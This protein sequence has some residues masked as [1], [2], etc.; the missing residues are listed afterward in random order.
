M[1]SHPHRLHVHRHVRDALRGVDEYASADPVRRLRDLLH[2][3]DGA[4][5]VGHV[6]QRH[7]PRVGRQQLVEVG[8]VERVVRADGHQ[9]QLGV[10]H[11]RD[12]LPR[13]EVG[14]V[15]HLRADDAVAGTDALRRPRVRHEVDRLRRVADEND[16]LRRRR[17]DERGDLLA[18]FLVRHRRFHRERVRAAVDVRVVLLV[19][20]DERRDDGSGLLRRGRVVQVDQR[21]PVDHPVQDGKVLPHLLDVVHHP[22]PCRHRS[23]ACS[24]C[25][26][27]APSSI[28]SST[29]LTK[30]CMSRLRATSSPMPRLLR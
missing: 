12:V 16:V 18:R 2:W 25:C 26:R 8:Q 17:V 13:H 22:P 29:S 21:H 5:H 15:L 9:A 14:V 3:C 10:V 28:A 20:V 19:V 23:T 1:K 4:E 6:R 7:E 11:P 30:P 27:T 24:T